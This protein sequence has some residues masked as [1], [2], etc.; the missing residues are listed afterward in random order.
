MHVPAAE[1]FVPCRLFLAGQLLNRSPRRLVPYG[2]SIGVAFL[3]ENWANR[4]IKSDDYT[5]VRTIQ[6][7]VINNT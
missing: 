3:V 7:A 1:T 2:K 5:A 4:P 6:Q